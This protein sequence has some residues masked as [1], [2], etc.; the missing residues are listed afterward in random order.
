MEG[1]RAPDI[2]L[3]VNTESISKWGKR[4]KIG[5]EKTRAVMFQIKKTMCVNI[6]III[7][8]GYYNSI[9]I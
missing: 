4:E 9:I 3:S 7:I 5:L 1:R 2:V 6:I 8:L